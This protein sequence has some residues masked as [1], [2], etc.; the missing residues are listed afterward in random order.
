MITPVWLSVF[1]NFV[2]LHVFDFVFASHILFSVQSMWCFCSEV[3]LQQFITC[4]LI[5]LTECFAIKTRI[6]QRLIN[7]VTHRDTPGRPGEVTTG[8]GSTDSTADYLLI[9][10]HITGTYHCSHMCAHLPHHNMS[11]KVWQRSAKMQRI[12]ASMQLLSF[13]RRGITGNFLGLLSGEALEWATTVW[14]KG[15]ETVVS[16]N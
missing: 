2:W 7:Y 4:L 1:L 11:R 9:A 16:Y 10:A 5:I 15:E 13:Y 12:S 3:S 14:G 6:Q 8:N